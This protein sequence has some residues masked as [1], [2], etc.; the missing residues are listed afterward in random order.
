MKLGDIY[1]PE[2]LLDALRNDRLVVFAGAGVSMGEPANLPDFRHLAKAI[3]PPGKELKA[4]EPEDRFLGT[5]KHSGINVHKIEEEELC[6]TNPKL[7]Q[8]HRDL[9]QLFLKPESVRIVTTNFDLLFEQATGEVFDL[10]PEIFL[11]PHY[12]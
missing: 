9:L 7:T 6:R 5:L 3:A 2:P 11:A 12:P 1:F 10:S 4:K 8:L